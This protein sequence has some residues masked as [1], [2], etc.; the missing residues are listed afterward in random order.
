[1]KRVSASRFFLLALCLSL[2]TLATHAPASPPYDGKYVYGNLDLSTKTLRSAGVTVKQVTDRAELPG[3]P[4]ATGDIGDYILENASARFVVRGEKREI[5]AGGI[6]G[7]GYVVDAAMQPANWDCF[8]GLLHGLRIGKSSFDFEYRAIQ[9]VEAPNPQT[10]PRLA[11]FG[12]IRKYPVVGV[13]TLM[14]VLPD[15]PILV[16]ETRLWNT[17]DEDIECQLMDQVNWGGLPL[18]VGG[19]GTPPYS[20]II[21]TNSHWV[22]GFLDGTGVSLVNASR[23]PMSL[24]HHRNQTESLYAAVTLPANQVIGSGAGAGYTRHIVLSV[25][26]AAP[27]SAYMLSLKGMPSGTLTGKVTE[28]S[29]GKPVADETIYVGYVAQQDGLIDKLPPYAFTRTN[30]HG[31]FSINLPIFRHREGKMLG[32]YYIESTSPGRAYVPAGISFFVRENEIERKNLTREEATQQLFGIQ[33]SATGEWI[34][35]KVRFLKAKGKV[36][37]GAAFAAGGARDFAYLKPGTTAIPLKAGTYTCLFSRGPEY[38]TVE[39]EIQVAYGESNK[40]VVQLE[41]VVPTPEFVSLDINQATD[42]SPDS[43]VTP[44]DLVLAAAGE[45]VDWIVS[46]DLNQATD[47]EEAIREQKLESFIRASR[48]AR[49]TFAYPKLFGEFYLFPLP[50]DATEEQLRGLATPEST[51]ADFFE[52][53]RQTFSEAPPLITVLHPLE[54]NRSYLLYYGL[55]VEN[56]ILPSG[57]SYSDA[58]DAILAVHGKGQVRSRYAWDMVQ[59]FT[60]NKRFVM[61]LGCSDSSTLYYS[62]PGYPRLYVHS[63]SDNARDLTE[64]ELVSTLKKHSYFITNGPI[65]RMR[66]NNKIAYNGIRAKNNGRYDMEFSVEAAPWVPIRNFE[67]SRSGSRLGF[68]TYSPKDEPVLFR[69]STTDTDN[70]PVQWLAYKLDPDTQDIRYLD[71]FA[72]MQVQGY[73]MKPVV[74]DTATQ[75]ALPLALWPPILM[76]GTRDDKWDFD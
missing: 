76:D 51:P 31:V 29:G 61:P 42:A 3:G 43:R 39:K 15:K 1:M 63:D 4:W 9:M 46:G 20:R 66:I 2:A 58:F 62:E 55:D 54:S 50:A 64:A 41:R 34:P 22:G 40:L 72:T 48:G 26:D 47:L 67:Y 24:K 25:D 14:Y 28:E 56:N 13:V 70:E 38:N 73:S 32:E 57:D 65:A 74:T 52:A 10:P 21:N 17:S 49:V 27:V 68:R 71:F 75:P 5:L 7:T 19:Y 30:A 23:E 53:V 45:G 18:F 11:V 44:E 36:N 60:E 37:L 8:G 16:Q 69:E 12:T 6:P 33:D 35:G 59:L